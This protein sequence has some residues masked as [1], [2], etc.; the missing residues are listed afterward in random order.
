MEDA[1]YVFTVGVFT[2]ESH[3]PF[4]PMVANQGKQLAVPDDKDER[5]SLAAKLQKVFGALPHTPHEWEIGSQDSPAH[6][7][8][9]PEAEL[10]PVH[11][12]VP[13]FWLPVSQPYL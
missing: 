7:A 1:G 12:R 5:L 9:Q 4:V 3:D 2:Y 8:N 10:F 6:V 13:R 11:V